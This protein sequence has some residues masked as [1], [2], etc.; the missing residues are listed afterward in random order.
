MFTKQADKQELREAH[1]QLR[2]KN[3]EQKEEKYIGNI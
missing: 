3:N 2:R 1:G